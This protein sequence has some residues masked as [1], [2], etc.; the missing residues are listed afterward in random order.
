EAKVCDGM[1]GFEGSEMCA[2]FCQPGVGCLEC[3]PG[4]TYCEGD[5][6][7]KCAADGMS[8]ELFDDCDEVQ[9]IACNPEIGLCDGEC[10]IENLQLNYIGCDYYPTIT[11]QHDSYNSGTKVF[12]AVVANT[13]EVPA[14]ITVTRGA[15]AVKEVTVPA[16]SVEAITLPWIAALTKG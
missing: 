11:L 10:V 5:D 1:G 4:A 12:A 15:M 7:M 8:S 3:E 16:K 9:G 14:H 13:A 2:G 6:V